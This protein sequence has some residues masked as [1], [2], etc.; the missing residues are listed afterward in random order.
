MGRFVKLWQ[1]L[2]G[3]RVIPVE[4][5]REQHRATW[6][7]AMKDC[8]GPVFK[9]ALSHTKIGG[10]TESWWRFLFFARS[11]ENLEPGSWLSGSSY[12]RT[13]QT[14]LDDTIDR[15]PA[16]PDSLIEHSPENSARHHRA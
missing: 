14:V 9:F 4:L 13:L 10:V 11:G 7:E 5:L 3:V 8:D 15:G 2:R 12:E 1:S 16:P 6:Q